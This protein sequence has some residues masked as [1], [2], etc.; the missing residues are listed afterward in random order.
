M[1][2]PE[3]VA[4]VEEI[5]TKLAESDATMLTEYRGLTVHDFADLRGSLRGSGT[6]YKVFK[7]TLARRAV[8]G[9]GLDDVTALLE[10]PVA[11]AFVRGDA[12]AAAKALRD[13]GRTNPALVVKGGLLGERVITPA[14]IEAL[15]DLPSRE[16]MLTQIAG[17]FQAPL[18]KAAGLFQAF[19][20]NFAY[21]VQAL[22]DQRVAGG[23]ALPA[24]KPEAPG[25]AEAPAEAPAE[26]EA[27]APADE[28]AADETPAAEAATAAEPE[29]VPAD[30]AAA[31]E[32]TE[33]E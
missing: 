11:I 23:E 4:V 29:A 1:A 31:P 27:A 28:A 33:S 32:S 18:T 7:N 20:R 2:R 22:I 10:G 19:T 8:A 5:R 12:A 30:D 17:M 25:E 16:V 15:A 21:G 13:F 3:K 24:A 9:A 26:A 14:D 6:E